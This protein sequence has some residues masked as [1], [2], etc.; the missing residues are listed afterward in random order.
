[1]STVP[2]SRDALC[3]RSI[4]AVVNPCKSPLEHKLQQFIFTQSRVR[5]T[6]GFTDPLLA[7]RDPGTSSWNT[8]HRWCRGT[9]AKRWP[10]TSATGKNSPHGENCGFILLKPK[11]YGYFSHVYFYRL[12]TD[13]FVVIVRMPSVILS[14]VF[15]LEWV[16]GDLKLPTLLV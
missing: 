10:I 15:D 14:W 6:G 13:D 11:R 1:M 16:S 4:R 2:R 9:P 12:S 7:W 5:G 8:A 3:R